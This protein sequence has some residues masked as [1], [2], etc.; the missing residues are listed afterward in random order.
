MPGSR[1]ERRDEGLGL[2]ARALGGGADRG[3][4]RGAASDRGPS[5]EPGQNPGRD[6]A[7]QGS[8][9]LD[10]GDLL[11]GLALAG[12]LVGASL[13]MSRLYEDG[14]WILPTWLTIGAALGLGAVLRRLGAGMVL[15]VVAMAAGFLVVAG[16]LLF[17]ETLWLVLPTRT[18]LTTLREAVSLGLTGVVDEAAP[19]EVTRYFLLLTCAGV[20]VVTF[21]AE[22]LAFRAAQPLLAIVPALG[23][24]VFPAM[25]RPGGARWY[26][27]WFLLGVA[28]L[29]LHEGRARLANWGRWTAHPATRPGSRWRLPSTPAAAAARRLAAGAGVLALLVPWALPGY[30]RAA[31]LDYKGVGGGGAVVEINPFVSLKR[32]LTARG[33]GVLFT[34]QAPQ[35]AYWRLV[36]LDF[37]DGTTWAPSSE[38]ND[39]R[40]RRPGAAS[41]GA[42]AAPG[43]KT[44]DLVQEIELVRLGGEW[45]PAAADPV[46]VEARLD[47]RQHEDTRGLTTTQPWRRR[48][49]YT[50][51]SRVVETT[52]RDLSAPQRSV[53]AVDPRYLDLPSSFSAAVRAEAERV[54]RGATTRFDKA[55][56][57]QDHFRA[58]GGFVYTLDVQELQSG[59]DQ[60]ADFVL[61]DK[62]GYCQQ[63]SAA[64]AAMARAIGI[65]ARVA[66]GFTSGTLAEGHYE[67]RARDAHAWPELWFDNVGWVRFEPTPVPDGRLSEPAYTTIAGRQVSPTTTTLPGAQNTPTPGTDTPR[68]VQ[69]EE[70]PSGGAFDAGGGGAPGAVRVLLGA[71]ALLL[72]VAAA[73]PT[74]KAVRLARA[75]RR[76]ARDPRG[77]VREA[78]GWLSDWADDAGMG[79]HPAE[80]P[81]RW[82][83]RLVDEFPHTTDDARALSRSF[84]LAEYSAATIDAADAVEAWRLAKAVRDQIGEA[85]G[86]RRRLLALFSLRSVLGDALTPRQPG[87]LLPQRR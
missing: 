68:A 4:D 53:P 21:S 75:R 48:F 26:V 31:L 6:A 36:A 47:V 50:V 23:L 1:R 51:T 79:R 41:E 74:T 16:N 28:G 34:V 65:P 78:W 71:L 8:R 63:F 29:L 13:S 73:I 61:H 70:D 87:T 37:F 56:A 54:T 76:S 57:L 11:L 25:V 66:V 42:D 58:S 7:A 72:L 12:L 59:G 30:G 55:L 64:M 24:F 38:L 35:R 52:A 86:W 85:I 77:G 19:V 40:F 67:V 45:M 69:P 49:S 33:D 10:R 9:L 20:W 17:P 15:S 2:I 82:T 44:S 60:L 14:R 3:A 32:T 84:T 81:S 62:R 27:L 46:R 5:R 39:R 22:G 18:T 83:E 80:T 43:A